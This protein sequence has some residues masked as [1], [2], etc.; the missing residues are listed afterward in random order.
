MNYDNTV[1]VSVNEMTG[2][3]ESFTLKQLKDACKENQQLPNIIST[4]LT[5][6]MPIAFSTSMSFSY[7]GKE[8]FEDKFIRGHERGHVMLGHYMC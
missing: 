8:E 3:T 5:L 1:I 2:L 7:F 4:F 6:G